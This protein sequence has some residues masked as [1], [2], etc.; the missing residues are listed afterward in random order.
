LKA[1]IEM[2]AADEWLAKPAKNRAVQH[3]SSLITPIRLVVR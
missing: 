2:I 1:D 3:L